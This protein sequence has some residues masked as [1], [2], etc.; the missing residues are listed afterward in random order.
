M[1]LDALMPAAPV[2]VATGFRGGLTLHVCAGGQ[3]EAGTLAELAN[4]LQGVLTDLNDGRE[5]TR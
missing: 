1:I 4:E 5:G 3:F 2:V